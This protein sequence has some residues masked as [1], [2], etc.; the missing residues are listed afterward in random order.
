MEERKTFKLQTGWGKTEDVQLEMNN[1]VNNNGMF[2]GLI[3]P[4]EEGG[5]EP[6]GDITVNLGVKAPDYC[7]YVDINNMPGL[8]KFIADNN[9]GEFTGLVQRS[10]F[11]EYPLYMFNVDELRKVCPDGMALYEANIGRARM[12]ENK[13][14]LR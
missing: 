3:C 5:Y 10:G 7:A 6:Y 4:S 9:L 11:V 2:I 13:D 8:E 1:Y 12:P 14:K